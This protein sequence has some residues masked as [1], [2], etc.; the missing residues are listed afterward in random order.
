MLSS[1]VVLLVSA[2]AV[3][4]AREVCQFVN[5]TAFYC[6]DYGATWGYCCNPDVDGFY[7]NC[8]TYTA[9]YGLWYFWM[10]LF[11]FLM[12]IGLCTVVMKSCMRP[13]TSTTSVSRSTASS[14]NYSAQQASVQ[15]DLP[16]TYSDVTKDGVEAQYQAYENYGQQTSETTSN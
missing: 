16:P 10:C 12:M 3:T 8:C 7:Q 11:G 4:E 14:P 5:G 9:F 1:I 13:K 6:V 2:F 15:M